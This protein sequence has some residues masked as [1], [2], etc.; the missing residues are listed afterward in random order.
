MKITSISAI[1]TYRSQFR[2]NYKILKITRHS[3][4]LSIS[5]ILQYIDDFIVKYVCTRL[6][7]LCFENCVYR[8]PQTVYSYR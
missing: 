7:A 2:E 1:N 4:F 8:E 6:K 5:N 3:W